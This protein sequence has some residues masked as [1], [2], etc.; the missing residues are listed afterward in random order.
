MCL[1]HCVAIFYNLSWLCSIK[2]SNQKNAE[3]ACGKWMCKRALRSLTKLSS[4]TKLKS[5]SCEE[6]FIDINKG[7]VNKW[8]HQILINVRP[9]CPFSR[10]KKYLCLN[11]L[12]NRVAIWPFLKMLVAIFG[13]LNFFGPGHPVIQLFW[14]RCVVIYRRTP[15]KKCFKTVEMTNVKVVANITSSDRKNPSVLF[16]TRRKYFLN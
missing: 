9:S 13:L 1:P 5:Y 3:N 15:C 6:S 8:R 11:C 14:P 7:V 4:V 16:S 12:Y 10:L 2:V